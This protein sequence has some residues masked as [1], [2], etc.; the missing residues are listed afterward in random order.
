MDVQ[1]ISVLIVMFAGVT[2]LLNGIAVA[3]TSDEDKK[4]SRQKVLQHEPDD[5]HRGRRLGL[6]ST[7]SSRNSIVNTISKI[8]PLQVVWMG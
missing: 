4:Q 6:R 7:A 2:L 1:T 3:F 5:A 8:A